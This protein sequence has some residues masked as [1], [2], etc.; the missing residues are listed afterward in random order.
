M[1]LVASV[2]AASAPLTP[3]VRKTLSGD[4][5]WP[6]LGVHRGCERRRC[7]PLPLRHHRPVVDHQHVDA[8]QAG[9]QTTQTAVRA[10]DS[11]D[12]ERVYDSWPLDANDT[13]EQMAKR[14]RLPVQ[15]LF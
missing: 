9:Q 13:I 15:A 3:K 1:T 8:P 11:L 5:V 12:H 6:V 10:C 2:A 4:H 7:H 14:L